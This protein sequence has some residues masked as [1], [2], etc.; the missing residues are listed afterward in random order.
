MDTPAVEAPGSPAAQDWGGDDEQ[1][2]GSA[3]SAEPPSSAGVRRNR[4]GERRR[5]RGGPPPNPPAFHALFSDVYQKP[6]F[7]QKWVRKV[8]MWKVRVRHYKP[9]AEAALDLSDAITGDAAPIVE[10]IPWRDLNR[11]DGIECIL[12]TLK[13]FDEQTVYHVGDL[14]EQYDQFLRH[15]GE[16]LLA[17][18]ARFEQLEQKCRAAHLDLYKGTARAFRLL[19]VSCLSPEHRRGILTSAGHDWDYPK[20]G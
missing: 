5:W 15:R 18:I 16:T 9:L 8:Q 7:Y 20:L 1:P 10:E 2:E 14:M 12:E 13:V 4:R 6:Q 11:E 19:R 3:S 17:M